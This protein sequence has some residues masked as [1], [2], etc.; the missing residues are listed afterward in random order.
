MRQQSVG[1]ANVV[2][3]RFSQDIRPRFS[4][5]G[6]LEPFDLTPSPTDPFVFYW[7]GDQSTAG[8][9]YSAAVNRPHEIEFEDEPVKVADHSS[10][11]VLAQDYNMLLVCSDEAA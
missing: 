9:E 8:T 11:N 1:A 3:Q 10:A 6:P 4:W 2:A 7:E 5:A